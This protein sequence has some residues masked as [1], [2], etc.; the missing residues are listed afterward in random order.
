M[1]GLWIAGGEARVRG[2]LARPETAPAETL[3]KVRLAGVWATSLA[4][5]RGCPGFTGAPGR[6][7]DGVALEVAGRRGRLK[8]LI[9]RG[10]P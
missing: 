1:R 9:E 4:L 10:A 2:D 5:G 8:A 6:E 7:F 3:V